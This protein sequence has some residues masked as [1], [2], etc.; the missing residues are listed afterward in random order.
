MWHPMSFSPA[1]KSGVLVDDAL[2]YHRRV[3][4]VCV[5]VSIVSMFFIFRI[6]HIDS[7]YD[8]FS[9]KGVQLHDGWMDGLG[10][11]KSAL[12]AKGMWGKHSVCLFFSN[13]GKVKL[14]AN[15]EKN[16]MK[17]MLGQD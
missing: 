7:C 16:T 11:V 14:N 10:K 2:H 15:F 12:G 17:S 1:K 4:C 9:P 5:C 8:G 6:F 13:Q 3:G